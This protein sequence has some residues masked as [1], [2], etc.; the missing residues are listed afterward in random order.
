L[1]EGADLPFRGS[2]IG[3]GIMI[4]AR[5]VLAVAERCR[6]YDHE[7]DRNGCDIY[8]STRYECNNCQGDGTRL[9]IHPETTAISVE[10]V[11][12]LVEASGPE[13]A[14]VVGANQPSMLMI[15]MQSQFIQDRVKET[16]S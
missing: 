8:E 10:E 2:R 13:F 9:V 11:L 5:G 15:E 12:A 6:Y 7:S 3:R 14:E 1:V 16:L 4:A